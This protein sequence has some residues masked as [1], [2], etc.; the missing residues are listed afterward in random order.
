MKY[1]FAAVIASAI[2]IFALQNTTPVSLRFLLWSLPETPLAA[3]I[4]ASV[5]A[6]IVLVGL[7]F[8]INRW[9]LRMRVRSLETR[10]AESEARATR[11]E[12][13]AHPPRPS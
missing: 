7:P 8:W 12:P 2:T 4:L 10:L 9:R 13:P 6:G 11:L 5:V 3:V 1:L